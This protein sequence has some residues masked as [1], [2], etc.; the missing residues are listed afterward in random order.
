MILTVL[1]IAR[2]FRGVQFEN[3]QN[4]KY[5]LFT[6]CTRKSCHF[7]YST[8]NKIRNCKRMMLFF[9]LHDSTVIKIMQELWQLASS[10]LCDTENNFTCLLCVFMHGWTWRNNSLFAKNKAIKIAKQLSDT[11]FSYVSFPWKLNRYSHGE[12]FE[13]IYCTVSTNQNWVILLSVL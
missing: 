11:F 10:V 7:F 2:A 5:L 1:T 6:N 8:F 3:C 4:H 13:I 9:N 12:Q